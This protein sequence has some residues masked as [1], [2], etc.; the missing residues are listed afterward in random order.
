MTT[1]VTDRSASSLRQSPDA[2][3]VEL[4]DRLA[5][6]HA[7]QTRRLQIKQATWAIAA[8]ALTWFALAWADWTWELAGGWR[9]LGCAL[10]AAVG[11]AAARFMRRTQDSAR[12]TCGSLLGTARNVEDRLHYFGQRLRTT[13]DYHDAH[14][15]PANAHP[16]LLHAMQR[17]T[18]SLVNQ[19]DWDSL[20]RSRS[21]FY[22]G[23]LL[24]A[25]AAIWACV[26][27]AIPEFRTATGRAFLLPW[28]YST[29]TFDPQSQ[30]VRMGESATIQVEV[31]GRPIGAAQLRYR[32]PSQPNEWR[33]VTLIASPSDSEATTTAP[34]TSA[35]SS[36]ESIVA[37]MSDDG[38]KKTSDE[39][40]SFHGSLVARLPHL[41]EDV[42]FEVVAGPVELPRGSITVLQPLRVVKLRAEITPPSYTGLPNESVELDA[43]TAGNEL[44]L[45]EGSNVELVATFNRSAKEMQ[46]TDSMQENAGANTSTSSATLAAIQPKGEQAVVRLVDVRRSGDGRLHAGTADGMSLDPLEIQF[47]VQ[48]D[49][50]P[51]VRFVEPPEKLAVIPTADVPM[52]IETR[53][54]L[55]LL[56]T[57]IAFQVGSG[58]V[59]TLLE[60]DARGATSL[61]SDAI[62]FLEDL[63][64]THQDA[65]SYYAYA[66]DN[67]FGQP[68]RV[69]TELRFID[70]RPF[71]LAYQQ[72]DSG[73]T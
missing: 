30:K 31:S 20:S 24:V 45:R 70:I 5:A 37:E 38:R 18:H 57:G 13:L 64:L 47:R 56:K 17:E 68:R 72:L 1:S 71:K 19:T 69:T 2:A 7:L 73:G 8:A 40:V 62:L 10:A 4:N 14:A 46:W 50:K 34:S 9:T 51:R 67:Y 61:D 65:I 41:K 54:D 15:S 66:E 53:D 16:H 28:H 55:G 12:S 39:H 63:S 58:P 32:H 33:E 60:S 6:F 52:R 59:E 11:M 21:T 3:L 42:E 43:N 49:E 27:I 48:T 36:E 23:T 26:A 44:K 22:C 35:A 25:G 29:V